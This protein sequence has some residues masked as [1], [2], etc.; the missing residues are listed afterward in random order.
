MVD[1]TSPP[2]TTMASGRCISEP[3]PVANNKGINA[4]AA[5]L[6]VIMTGRKRRRAPSIICVKVME[7]RGCKNM[8]KMNIYLMQMRQA[9][10]VLM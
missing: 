7:H 9:R 3:G 8:H 6:A 5:L 10:Q 4:K 1:V 2:M